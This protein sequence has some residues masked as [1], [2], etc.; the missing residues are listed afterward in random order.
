LPETPQLTTLNEE[1][2]REVEPKEALS[3][4]KRLP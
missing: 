3:G 4:K 1:A 2:L